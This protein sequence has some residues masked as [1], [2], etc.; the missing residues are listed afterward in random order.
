MAVLAGLEPASVFQYFEDICSIPHGSGNTKPI[1]D[2]CVAFAKKHG[3]RYIQDDSNNVILFKDGTAGYEQSAPV[4]LQGHLDMV[5]EKTADC[6][7]D[8]EKDGLKLQ[9]EDGVISADGTT[10]GGDDGIAVAYALAILASDDIPHPPLEVV[11][12]VDE[13]VGMLGAAAL[14]C[15]PLQARTMLNMDSEDEGYLLVSCAGGVRSVC[16]LPIAREASSGVKVELKV[17]GLTGG[18]SGVEIDKERANANVLIG[19]ALY[20]LNKI[21]PY[22]LLGVNG[23]LKDNAIPRESTAELLVSAEKAAEITAFAEM[24][25]GVFANEYRMPDPELKLEAMIGGPV[26][27]QAMTEESRRRTVSA[28]MQLPRGIQRM[29]VDIPGLVQ[30][31]LNL[32][33]LTT[34]EECVEMSFAVRSSLSTEKEELV[35]RLEDLMALLGGTVTNDG[36]YPAWEYKR[37][38]KLRD[39]MVSVFEEMYGRKPVVQA[40]HAGVECGLFSGALPGLDCVS[41]GPDMQD[42]HTTSES[43]SIASVQRT[44]NYTLEVLKRLK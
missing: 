8:F 11:L 21:V 10:L 28:L 19:R 42:I 15:S 23:G 17:S 43:M 13:E 14:D 41:F 2:Y 38:S 1:S 29:S 31:S 39:L 36:D 37:D 3:L 40:L 26:S 33:I 27:A 18:H 16:R 24:F 5:C 4:M 35:S 30:T 6:T 22:A 34:E 20:E 9:V 32:G 7:I 12:T 25:D 44:W